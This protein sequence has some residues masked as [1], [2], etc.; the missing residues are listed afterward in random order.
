MASFILSFYYTCFPFVLKRNNILIT[1][2]SISVDGLNINFVMVRLAE[3]TVCI[4]WDE[5]RLGQGP[6]SLGIWT[7]W[8]GLEDYDPTLERIDF[9]IS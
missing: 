2:G 5:N 6:L 7:P 1:L 9:S 4:F 8:R 3:Y